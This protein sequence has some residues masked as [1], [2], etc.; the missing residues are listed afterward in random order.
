MQLSCALIK[1]KRVKESMIDA[2]ENEGHLQESSNMQEIF[3]SSSC[4][5][6][7]KTEIKHIKTTDVIL[8]RTVETFCDSI[9]PENKPT[10]NS[11]T[12]HTFMTFLLL[13]WKQFGYERTHL[14]INH[15][16][17]SL[18]EFLMTKAY[19]KWRRTNACHA[20]QVIEDWNENKWDCLQPFA[21]ADF[22]DL[23]LK[24]EEIIFYL[25]NVA[26]YSMA[27]GI[28]NRWTPSSNEVEN[29]TCKKSLWNET[30]TDEG[31]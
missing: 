21:I 1:G 2:I 17:L 27:S 6:I 15:H 29:C 5:R 16:N 22:R 14:W 31:W 19:K 28:N 11:L 23:E 10:I 12:K 24:S 26:F 7:V 13:S 20:Y 3:C 8:K 18:A 30:S 9:K 4:V 25:Q